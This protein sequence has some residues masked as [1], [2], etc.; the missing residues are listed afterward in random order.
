DFERGGAGVS[1]L[2]QA[3]QRRVEQE[4]PRMR[5]PF[6][7]RSTC[8]NI[9]LKHANERTRRHTNRQAG[10]FLAPEGP[11][12]SNPSGRH[13]TAS[14]ERPCAPWENA[15]NLIATGAHA[16]A[17]VPRGAYRLEEP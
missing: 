10:L 13:A 4:A 11:P 7:L 1:E 6:G 17:R 14:V 3:R 15:I 5:A 12:C 8:A 2:S 16:G 9:A